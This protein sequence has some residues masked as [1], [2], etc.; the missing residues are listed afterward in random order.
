MEANL[1]AQEQRTLE[2]TM[3]LLD[4][5]GDYLGDE[6]YDVTDPWK[7]KANLRIR[8]TTMPQFRK[9]RCLGVFL[10]L[11]QDDLCKVCWDRRTLDYLTPDERIALA[12]LKD[13]KKVVTKKEQ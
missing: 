1:G 8:S 11:V 9:N 4:E 12:E 5:F 6:D 2:N 3:S 10:D 13:A 7:R